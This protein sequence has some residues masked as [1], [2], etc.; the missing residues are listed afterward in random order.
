[1][2]ESP[3]ARVRRLCLEL[4]ESCEKFAWSAPTFRVGRTQKMFA[5]YAD[6]HHGDPRLT[7]WC[8]AP[9]GKQA[10]LVASEPQRYFRPPYVG[11]K[12]W[13]GLDLAKFTDQELRLHL[14]EAWEQVAPRKLLQAIQPK[15]PR[16]P[17][18]EKSARK[19]PALEKKQ[20]AARRPT[21][22]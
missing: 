3:L 20:A 22:G 9:V 17:T 14:R 1:M 2:A 7:V 15:P 6:H 8:H 10:V 18:Q 12:G 21:R 13:I 11:V 4:P 19:K 5:T 16:T